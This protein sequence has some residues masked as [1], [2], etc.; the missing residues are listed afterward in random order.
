MNKYLLLIFVFSVLSINVHAWNE[1]THEKLVE[2]IYYSMPENLQ[3]QLNLTELEYGAT[4]PDLVFHDTTKHHYPNSKDLAYKYL[5]N[6]IS[7]NDFSYNFGVA[8]HYI[9]DS[10]VSPHYISGENSTDHSKF[11]NQ[12]SNYTIK[13]EC[14]N[15]NYT[16]NDLYIGAEN[17]ADW[18]PWMKTKNPEIPEKEAEQAQQFLYS[19]AIQML[20]YSCNEQMEY[21]E[22]SVITMPDKNTAY[23]V[24]LIF[25]I[26]L[27]L[28]KLFK[29]KLSR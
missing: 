6:I 11:E 3:K 28:F 17:K 29:Q 19:I 4:A 21:N 7:L 2:N 25:L 22:K 15:Y 13:T 24:V 27:I 18:A 5:S 9:S 14:G 8:S 26:L 1:I 10:F 16:L 12:L 23:L 20:N